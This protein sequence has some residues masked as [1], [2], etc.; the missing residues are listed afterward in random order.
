MRLPAAARSALLF[1]CPLLATCTSALALIKF[2]DGH[3]E[4]F[5]TGSAG[6]TYDSNLFASSEG[7][8]DTSYNGNVELEYRRKAGMLGVG[9]TLDCQISRFQSHT[10]ENFANPDFKAELTKDSGRTTGMLRVGVRRENRAETAINLRTKSWNY[11]AELT[12]KYPVIERY[13]ISGLAGYSRRDFQENTSLVDIDTYNAGA[14]LLYALN[15]QRDLVVGYRH[16]ITDTTASTTDT[17]DSATVGVTGRILPKLSGSFRIGLQ[18]RSVERRGAPDESF[19]SATSTVGA[20]WTVSTRLSVTATAA[21]DFVTVATD[22]SVDSTSL[23]MTA[24]YAMNSK[25]S[26]FAGI[27]GGRYRFLDTGARGRHDDFASFSAGVARAFNEHLR[28]SLSYL[29]YKN[30]ST[31]ALSDFDRHTISV[32]VSSRW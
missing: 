6:M 24:Q 23:G 1:L 26:A 25:T 10:E 7:D 11:D 29:Y 3:D 14:D 30:W 4:I 2:N 9:A 5:V 13:S 8:G 18:Q 22:A 32:N 27:G 17:D 31:L 16:R 20:T 28:V 12:A 21:K 15:S 19:S